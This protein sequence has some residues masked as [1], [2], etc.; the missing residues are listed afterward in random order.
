MKSRLACAVLLPVFILA[1]CSGSLE[2]IAP[3]AERKLPQEVTEAMQAKGMSKNSPIMMR[4]FKEEGVLEVWKQK[5]DG[6]YDRIASYDICKW[7][8]KLGPKYTEGDRQAPEG[9]YTV[10]PQQ[11]NPNS[12]YHLSFNVGFPNAYDQ[13]NGRTGQH[14]MVHGACSSAGCY[15]MTDEQVEEI[16]A[17][18]RDAF[19]GGQQA[20]QLQAFPFRMTP[21]NMARYRDDPNYPF[22]QMLKEGYDHFEITKSPPKVDVCERRYVFNRVAADGYSFEPTQA[23][24][25]S[26]QPQALL[27]AYQAY[28]KKQDLAVSQAA[29]KWSKQQP[30]PTIAGL[31]EAKLVADWSRRRARGERVTPEPPSLTPVMVAK[32]KAPE[33]APVTA[34]APPPRPAPA[35]QATAAAEQPPAEQEAATAA[36]EANGAVTETQM[37]VGATPLTTGS[38]P[39]PAPNPNRP[40]AAAAQPETAPEPEQGRMSRLWN[41]FRK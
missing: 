8:G 41:M 6:R 29:W 24:P 27:T 3:K 16:Y 34:Y 40:A 38:T 20:F 10:R 17:F 15:S 32:Q 31:E 22:W 4:I 25:P 18:A 13:A 30:K 11:M 14:L 26:T 5:R 36:A 37:Q 19:R 35:T 21:E 39:A 1:G 7:S 23:C 9:F 2:D 33:S 28:K 12:S